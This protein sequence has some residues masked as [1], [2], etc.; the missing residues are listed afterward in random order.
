MAGALVDGRA[1]RL[2]VPDGWRLERSAAFPLEI[3]APADQ[4]YRASFALSLEIGDAA[5]PDWLAR[6]F[7]RVHGIQRAQFAEYEEIER[8]EREL[9]GRRCLAVLYR[10]C[11]VGTRVRL[12]QLLLL[13]PLEPG[14]AL[15]VDAAAL[16]ERARDYFPVF[17]R[18]LHSLDWEDPPVEDP[19]SR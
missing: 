17:E 5:R 9:R 19:S 12:Q 3:Y 1:V 6:C 2:D 14:R 11:P 16:A 18:V 15:R 7:A 4:G 13:V 10:W 8:G